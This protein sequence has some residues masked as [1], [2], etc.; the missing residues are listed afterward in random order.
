MKPVQIY[1][2]IGINHDGEKAK[3]ARLIAEAARAGV[4]GIKFQYR[5]PANA[6]SGLAREIGDEILIREITRITCHP[7][8]CWNLPTMPV[9]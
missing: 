3:A 2:E 4:A 6:Y 1:A 7:K 5:N 8:R 9:R